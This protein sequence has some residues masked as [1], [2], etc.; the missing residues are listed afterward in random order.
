MCHFFQFLFLLCKLRHIAFLVLDHILHQSQCFLLVKFLQLAAAG[1]I[2]LLQIIFD[3]R[4]INK[5]NQRHSL[6]CRKNQRMQ[7]H[8]QNE[9]RLRNNPHYL[10]GRVAAL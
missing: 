7:T 4:V 9:I 5:A 10:I 8:A 3:L 6:S 1:H 2:Q